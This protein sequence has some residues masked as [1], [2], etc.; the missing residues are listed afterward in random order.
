MVPEWPWRGYIDARR[1]KGEAPSV[2]LR[3][4]PSEFQFVSL[5]EGARAHTTSLTKGRTS[6]EAPPAAG[7]PASW[8]KCRA[9]TCRR[10]RR[11]SPT[12]G[13]SGESPRCGCARRTAQPPA[14]MRANRRGPCPLV[15]CR[16]EQIRLY[17][18]L[19]TWSREV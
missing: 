13:D 16:L 6:S 14:L 9:S 8:R 7:P 5:A 17:E 2:F 18:T 4:R 11:F 12:R 15:A 1:E 10:A 3:P 19:V